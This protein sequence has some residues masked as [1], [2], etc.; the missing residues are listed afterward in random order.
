VKK[1][2]MTCNLS[3]SL[4]VSILGCVRAN[5]LIKGWQMHILYKER[6]EPHLNDLV[7]T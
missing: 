4:A 3:L 5:I 6:R 1:N 2:A 7:Q